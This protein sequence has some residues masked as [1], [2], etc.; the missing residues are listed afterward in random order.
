[1]HR[2][3]LLSRSARGLAPR[4]APGFS[5]NQCAAI[6]KTPHV[7]SA[8]GEFLD[9]PETAVFPCVQAQPAVANV[10]SSRACSPTYDGEVWLTQSRVYNPPA[11]TRSAWLPSSLT[12]PSSRTTIR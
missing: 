12:R 9:S 1:M 7:E 6:P 8:P 11:A 4:S 5:P 10:R 2:M 3:G